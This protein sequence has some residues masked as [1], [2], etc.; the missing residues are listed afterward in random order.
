MLHWIIFSNYFRNEIMNVF[1][2]DIDKNLYIAPYF[3]ETNSDGITDIYYPSFIA[4][5][6]NILI[7]V[8]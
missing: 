3:Y 5:I 4:I 7:T 1:N 2:L 8:S 6:V